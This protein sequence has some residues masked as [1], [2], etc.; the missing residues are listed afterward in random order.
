[1]QSVHVNNNLY[2]ISIILYQFIQREVQ[3]GVRTDTVCYYHSNKLGI[4][5]IFSKDKGNDGYYRISEHPSGKDFVDNVIW[6]YWDNSKPA[7]FLI[8]DIKKV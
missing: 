3:R 4:Y 7:L 6:S 1:M 5:Q 2:Y 8:E